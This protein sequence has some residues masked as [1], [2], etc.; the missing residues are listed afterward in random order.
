ME[1]SVSTDH[2][3]GF[4]FG[5]LD[6]GVYNLDVSTP[7]GAQHHESVELSGDREIRVELR[8]ASLAGRVIDAM[9]SSPLSGVQIALVPDGDRPAPFTDAATDAR[10]VFRLIEVGDGAWKLRA[11][12]EGYSPAEQE[13]RVDGPDPGE[14]E[15]RMNPT[16]GVTVEALL[17]SG[18]PPDRLRVAVLDAGGKTI[19]SGTYP[20]GE[21]GRTR[22]SNVPPGS[23]QLLVE[24]DQS[25]AV[26]VAASSPGPPV[27]VLLQPGGQVRVRVPALAASDASAKIVLT[28]SGGPFRD[29]DWDGSVRSEWD[30]AG[31]TRL[32]PRM[33]AGIWQVVAR[34]PDGRSWSGTAT[35]APGGAAEVVLK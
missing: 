32:F 6:N 33:P 27:H 8:T 10:G 17:A 31:G 3:G 1:Q 22:L 26:T 11:T 24:S 13:V 19:A 4:R 20:T 7:N 35:V 30:L 9:D 14:I 23:W 18:Q 34:T 28:G 5:G 25:A 2:L 21:N 16:E 12:R 29:I 15:I